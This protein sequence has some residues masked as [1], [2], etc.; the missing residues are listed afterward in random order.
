[1]WTTVHRSGTESLFHGGSGAAQVLEQQYMRMT[2]IKWSSTSKKICVTVLS[3]CWYNG[4]EDAV[5]A[6]FSLS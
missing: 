1:M 2:M 5:L 3:G 4:H 6:L